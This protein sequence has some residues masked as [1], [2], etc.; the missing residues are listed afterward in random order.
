MRK[1]LPEQFSGCLIG[2]SLGDALGAVVE[3]RSPEDCHYYV[4]EVLKKGQAGVMGRGSYRFGQYT[5]DSQLARELLQS[6]VH[7]GRFDP[8]DYASRIAAIFAENRIVGKGRA[9]EAAAIKL[10][11]G[12][13]WQQAGTPAPSA[14]NGSAMRAGPIGLIFYN[15]FTKL[16]QAA[17]EQGH[18]THQDQRCAAGS[19]IIAGA[20]AITLTEKPLDQPDFLKKLSELAAAYDQDF[21]RLV[22][23]LEEWVTLS[24]E[25]AA[26]Q[27]IEAGKVSGPND[28]WWGISPYVVPSVLWSLYS[29]LQTPDDYWETICTAIIAGGD[30]DTTAAMAGAIS[31]AYL[32]LSSIPQNLAQQLND[33]GTWGYSELIELA[34]KCYQ[35]VTAQI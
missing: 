15:D 35:F 5:D 12:V 13:P 8:A 29:F 18:I 7:C 21:S 10:A 27:I 22:L 4:N 1:P 3:G 32:G 17:Y 23:K 30:V 2:Q 20:V 24:V 26:F 16:A 31:G 34:N 14:G 9:T 6:F 11:Q 25:Q 19:A 28:G 33:R